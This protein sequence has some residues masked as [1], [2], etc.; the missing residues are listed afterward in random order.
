MSKGKS[1]DCLKIEHFIATWQSGRLKG[2]G[3]TQTL[4]GAKSRNLAKSQGGLSG[5]NGIRRVR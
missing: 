4:Q 1:P 5:L 2:V 3:K